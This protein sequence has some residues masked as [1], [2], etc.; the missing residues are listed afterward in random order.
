MREFTD[1]FRGWIM[2]LA[3]FLINGPPQ[4]QARLLQQ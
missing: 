4:L 1:W 3:F 2:E